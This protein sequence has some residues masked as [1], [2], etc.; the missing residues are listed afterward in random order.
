M[1]SRTVTAL[2]VAASAA[3]LTRPALA[4]EIQPLLVDRI[5]GVSI[6][7]GP[8]GGGQEFEIQHPPPADPVAL[9]LN[10]AQD[11]ELASGSAFMRHVSTIGT[12]SVHGFAD[13]GVAGESQ[14][15]A[16]MSGLGTVYF[17]TDFVLDEPSPYTLVG[18]VS[19]SGNSA[20]HGGSIILTSAVSTLVEITI[21]SGS[22]TPPSVQFDRT[23][24][25]PAGNYSLVGI[26][27]ANMLR[28]PPLAQ[29]GFVGYDMLFALTGCLCDL[30]G[31]SD[32]GLQDLALLL[33]NFG[34]DTAAFDDGDFDSDADVDITDLAR[35]LGRFGTS[36][37]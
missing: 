25:L 28:S 36:C 34:S 18:Y 4:A 11:C 19:S 8:C 3:A 37:E 2:L 32:V 29:A 24:M 7:V 21:Q 35:L 1:R 30:D 12:K 22:G 6:F 23:G 27:Q 9:E 31:S 13:C 14:T 15:A 16:T 10:V 20:A 33:A 26:A 17:Q 5:L